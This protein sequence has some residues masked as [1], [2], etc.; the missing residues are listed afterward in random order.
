MRD[1]L[2]HV[3]PPIEGPDDDFAVTDGLLRDILPD[4]TYQ[5]SDDQ[6]DTITL[7]SPKDIEEPYGSE[8][9]H[10]G[11]GFTNFA[12][13][14]YPTLI[15]FKP[16]TKTSIDMRNDVEPTSKSPL[17]PQINM[18]SYL[19]S[20]PLTSRQPH[21]GAISGG[22]ESWSLSTLPRAPEGLESVLGNGSKSLRPSGNSPTRC[23][24]LRTIEVLFE[25]L[26]RKKH[27][28]DPA[29]LDSI[30]ASQKKALVRC[31]SVLSCSTC[32]AR[33]E[34][35]LLLGLITERLATLCESTV[36][37]YLK[38]VQRRSS[39]RTSSN[40]KH[41]SRTSSEETNKVFLGRYEIESPEEWSSLIRVLIVIQIRNLRILLGDTKRLQLPERTQ[42]SCP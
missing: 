10:N 3:D 32:A 29:A 11:H 26:E 23:E 14:L 6:W 12:L 30:L 18:D 2:N 8:S 28:I 16:Y 38:E 27:T 40:G 17:S 19:A 33:S 35:I 15:N 1:L 13:S 31:N 34:Y 36:S 5:H 24:C 22:P 37:L 7:P 39:F 20:P 9:A 25:E 21:F 4:Y 42:R 41:H